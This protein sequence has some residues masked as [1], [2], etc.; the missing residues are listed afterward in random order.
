M[1]SS[2]FKIYVKSKNKGLVENAAKYLAK[3]LECKL[4]MN[5]KAAF[6]KINNY[7]I[8]SNPLRMLERLSV[9]E[10]RRK[11]QMVDAFNKIYKYAFLTKKHHELSVN[12]LRNLLLKIHNNK[13]NQGMMKIKIEAFDNM[14]KKYNVI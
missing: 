12:H 4:R 6:E 14:R 9:Y 7:K 2:L 13:L 11:N 5:N 1:L 8:W 10:E 3:L